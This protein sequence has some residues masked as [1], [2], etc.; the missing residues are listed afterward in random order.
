M[1]PNY[2]LNFRTQTASDAADLTTWFGRQS[3]T[4]ATEA[5]PGTMGLGEVVS[6]TAAGSAALPAIVAVAK[7]WIRAHRTTVTLE[8][9]GRGS[10]LV[11]GTTD[12]ESLVA[13]LIE[14]GAQGGKND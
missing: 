9:E 1:E 8:I 2:R 12:I 7:E 10:F 14:P 13:A 5:Q 11:E 4:T 3:V 6:C